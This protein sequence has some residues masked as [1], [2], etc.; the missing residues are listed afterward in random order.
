MCLYLV[1][2]IIIVHSVI[3]HHHS[4]ID[5]GGHGKYFLLYLYG[6]TENPL[7]AVRTLGLISH[8]E[9]VKGR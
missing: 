4:A 8:S 1:D 5:R 3:A 2:H 6:N 7:V 9:K